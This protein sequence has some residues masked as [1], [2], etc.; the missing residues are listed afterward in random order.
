MRE[1]GESGE[2][3]VFFKVSYL[4]LSSHDFPKYQQTLSKV[5]V[6]PSIVLLIIVII[7]IIWNGKSTLTFLREKILKK[8]KEA[9]MIFLLIPLSWWNRARTKDPDPYLGGATRMTCIHILVTDRFAAM[10]WSS[11]SR[12]PNRSEPHYFFLI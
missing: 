12:L 8:R 5:S 4:S 7:I 6:I 10:A 11:L 1:W 2:V 3:G 9:V